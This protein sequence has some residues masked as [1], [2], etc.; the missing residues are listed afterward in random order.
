MLL[1]NVKN[2]DTGLEGEVY[3]KLFNKYIEFY[4]NEADLNYVEKCAHYLN[5][6]SD[7]VIDKL[8]EAQRKTT[9]TYSD[10]YPFGI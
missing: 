4:V 1:R 10:E 9:A 3:F 7:A 5:S 8:C 6:L 2:H